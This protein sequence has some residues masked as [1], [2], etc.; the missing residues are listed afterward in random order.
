MKFLE[1]GL[2]SSITLATIK[3]RVQNLF[4]KI[5]EYSIIGGMGG[6][7]RGS[8]FWNFQWGKYTFFKKCFKNGLVSEKNYLFFP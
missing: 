1:Y 5:M 2:N 4:L 6:A 3:G 8:F 7:Q